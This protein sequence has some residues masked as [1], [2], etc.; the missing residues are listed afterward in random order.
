M[1]KK[2]LFVCVGNSCRSQM[3]EGFAKYFGFI[4][5]SSAG[6]KPAD[7]VSG[8]A[9]EVMKEKEIDITGQKPKLLT[10]GMIENVDVIVSMGCG[11]EESCPVP[12]GDPEDWG[13]DD[14]YGCSIEVYRAV[15]DEIEKRV[16]ELLGELGI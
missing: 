1:V 4:E 12:L 8:K 10:P 3:A 5:A 13:L 11:V 15:R 7:A 6:T 9:I 16:K 14:P 2:V